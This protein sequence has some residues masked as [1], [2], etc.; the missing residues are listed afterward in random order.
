MA[1]PADPEM[2]E[3]GRA[4]VAISL[5]TRAPLVARTIAAHLT[6][7]SDHILREGYRSMLSAQQVKSLLATAVSDHLRKLNRVAACSPPMSCLSV[8]RQKKI[9]S[10]R[11]CRV[12]RSRSA[13]F[14]DKFHRCLRPSVVSR[15]GQVDSRGA[16]AHLRPLRAEYPLGIHP[17]AVA[18]L[19]EGSS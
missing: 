17:G 14:S 15:Y 19:P 13:Q 8:N 11:S 4:P 10:G 18:Q 3:S 5:Q 6:L 9:F 2:R 1:S 7:K 12:R 16:G